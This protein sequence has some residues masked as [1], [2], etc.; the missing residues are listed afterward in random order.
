MSAPLIETRDL[1][2]VYDK[3]E[4][5]VVAVRETSLSIPQGQFVA[6]SGASGSGKST[7]M[8]LIGCLDRP[9]QGSLMFEGHEVSKLSKKQLAALRNR[10]IGFIFQSFNLLGRTTVLDNTALP[11][12]Y[13]GVSL[14]KR[15]ERATE[16]LTQL[17]LGD[18]MHHLPNQLSGGSDLAMPNPS[19]DA[20]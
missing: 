6:I 3:C 8:H 14:R 16:T 4:V 18:R 2:K 1:W 12:A 20:L 5:P 9:T 17:G 15:R 11:L 10:R 7:F 19:C 13:Q